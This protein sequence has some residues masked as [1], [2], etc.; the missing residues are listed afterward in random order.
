MTASRNR[1]SRVEIQRAFCF[2]AV[3]LSVGAGACSNQ[4]SGGTET[5]SVLDASIVGAWYGT[6]PDGDQCLILC[7]NGRLFTG[8]RPCTEVTAG[9][10]S[11]YLSYSVAEST[12]TASSSPQCW[13][14]SSPCAQTPMTWSIV[15]GHA[16]VEWCGTVMRLD[17]VADSSPM[18]DDPVR[19]AC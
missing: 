8:D 9:D 2:A 10:F 1:G 14:A 17:R 11:S 19:P 5:G 4:G 18:C 15:G 12:L 13:F 3:L 7:E 6:G 16:T